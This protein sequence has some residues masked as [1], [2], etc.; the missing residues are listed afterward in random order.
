[1]H[2]NDDGPMG[3]WFADPVTGENAYP[4]RFLQVDVHVGWRDRGQ[5]ARSIHGH[6]EIRV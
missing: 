6:S 3:T 2:S 1:M 5:Y 4:E